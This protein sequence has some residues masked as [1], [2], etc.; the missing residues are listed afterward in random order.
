MQ[1]ECQREAEADGGAKG[2]E[3][4]EKHNPRDIFRG[5]ME[6]RGADE[7]QRGE[8]GDGE[9]C[10]RSRATRWSNDRRKY[11]SR[12]PHTNINDTSRLRAPRR[13]DVRTSSPRQG[14][15]VLLIMA[16]LP[17]GK[18][19]SADDV[20]NGAVPNDLVSRRRR[21]SIYIYIYI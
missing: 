6:R 8:E 2:G 20:F 9:R 18:K 10:E 16:W 19:K 13:A 3:G 4:T 21:T 14:R 1:C 7:P 12:Q 11:C 17:K 5:E 15:K